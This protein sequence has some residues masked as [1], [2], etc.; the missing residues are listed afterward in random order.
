MSFAIYDSH[1]AQ[2]FIRLKT[3]TIQSFYLYN[4]LLLVNQNTS[5]LKWNKTEHFHSTCLIFLLRNPIRTMCLNLYFPFY[6]SNID[7]HKGI[8]TFF[9]LYRR[10]SAYGVSNSSTSMHSEH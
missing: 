1:F 6:Y 4:L 10:R 5:Y 8:F 7:N 2:F 3:M 9:L